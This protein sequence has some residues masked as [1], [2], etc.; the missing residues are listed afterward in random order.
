MSDTATPTS[1]TMITTILYRDADA[2]VDFLTRTFGFRPHA[3]YRGDGG[4]VIHA[5]LTFGN[6]MI[7]LGPVDKGEFGKRFLTM[8]NDAGGRCT[9]SVYVIVRDI[10]AHH[11]HAS[12]AGADIVMPLREVGEGG[13]NY[14]VRDPEGH[15]WSFGT[16]DPWEST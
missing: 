10:D 4:T 8:P 9:H 5:E 15:L 3:V 6:G 11:A 7:M 14:S 1:V 16:Y 13:R 2:A 12:A